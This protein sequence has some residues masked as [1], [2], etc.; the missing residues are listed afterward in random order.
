MFS[1][2]MQ[3]LELPP[4]QHKLHNPVLLFKTR[5]YNMKSLKVKI[6]EEK[7]KAI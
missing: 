6:T 7:N 2:K 3:K 1:M 5:Y 4:P